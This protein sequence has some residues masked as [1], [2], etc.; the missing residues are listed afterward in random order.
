VAWLSFWGE[1]QICIW[2]SWCHCHSLSLASVKSRLVLVLAHPCNPGQS[3]EGCKTG[4]CLCVCVCQ[5]LW[6]KC[7][8][9]CWVRFHITVIALIIAS[10]SQRSA[11]SE[12]YYHSGM[13][14]CRSAPT[15]SRASG[16]CC[17][18]VA[19]AGC[20]IAAVRSRQNTGSRQTLLVLQFVVEFANIW[21]QYS[22]STYASTHVG[23]FWFVP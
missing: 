13:F 22:P 9:H 20:C 3:P 16:Q 17:C 23:V 1:V 7:L 8:V 6:A 14:V 11:E 18:C 21:A 15:A 12:P 2:P 4:V 19:A 10:R 5:V